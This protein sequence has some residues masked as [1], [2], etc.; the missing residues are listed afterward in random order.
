[1]KIAWIVGGGLFVLASSVAAGGG[2][3][4]IDPHRGCRRNPAVVGPCFEVN[5]RAFAANGTPG[6]R[7]HKAGTK[8]ILGVLPSEEEIAPRCFLDNINFEHEVV[9]TFTV[10]PFSVDRPGEMQVVCI[11][12]VTGD[13]FEQN[14][15]GPGSK[16]VRRL[17]ACRLK[18]EAR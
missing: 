17:E 13:V 16:K 14:P 10:C 12:A 9:G 3:K 11:E 15:T 7:I 6:I 5:G 18:R 4:R 2:P 1:M 8:R